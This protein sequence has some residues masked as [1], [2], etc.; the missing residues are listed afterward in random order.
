MAMMLAGFGSILT[1]E[2]GKLAMEH[3]PML[4]QVAKSAVV[5]VGKK[6]FDMVLDKNPNFASFLGNFGIHR[7][8]KTNPKTFTHRGSHRRITYHNH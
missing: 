3:S 4:Q 1:H 6:T 7:F 2:L 8:S 5:E